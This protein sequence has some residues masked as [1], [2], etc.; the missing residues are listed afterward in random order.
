MLHKTIFLSRLNGNINYQMVGQANTKKCATLCSASISLY[1][2]EYEVIFFYQSLL[3]M[4]KG[5]RGPGIPN[6]NPILEE[7]YPNFRGPNFMPYGAIIMSN[8]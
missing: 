3:G 2:Q 4:C 1:S 8:L 5:G 6:S 7:K